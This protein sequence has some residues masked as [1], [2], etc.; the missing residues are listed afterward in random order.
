MG[1]T[2]IRT[3]QNKRNILTAITRGA[4]QGLAVE[5]AGISPRAFYSWKADDAEFAEDIKKARA[6]CALE[7]LDKITS[8]EQW[9]AH[10]W[11]LERQFPE[12]FSLVQK[13]EQ[14]LAKHGLIASG[15]A[16]Q[17]EDGSEELPAEPVED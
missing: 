5:A 3:E 7:R 10:A 12:D 6:S 9:Q 2:S 13:I 1:V 11:W 4:S 15:I 8:A 17:L 16:A 14:V